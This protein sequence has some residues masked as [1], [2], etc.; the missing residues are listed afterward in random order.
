MSVPPVAFFVPYLR[1]ER[2][3][4]G[5]VLGGALSLLACTGQGTPP[6]RTP[7]ESATAQA[8]PDGPPPG[9]G[10]P[11]PEPPPRHWQPVQGPPAH[12]DPAV[13][14]VFPRTLGGLAFRGVQR[15][16]R[17]ELGYGLRYQNNADLWLDVYVYTLGHLRIPDGADASELQR[18]FTQVE[19]D[20]QA[21][22]RAGHYTQLV[23]GPRARVVPSGRIFQ[24]GSYTYRNR[25][26]S[27]ASRLYLS[28]HKGHYVKIRATWW[29]AMGAA[30][31]A[32]V[33]RAVRELAAL[34][35]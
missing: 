8:P 33:E 14:I 28:G 3:S 35:R 18:H 19:G 1:G 17:A 20:I 4:L 16:G 5:L 7:G 27:V 34:M 9:K 15:F 21:A 23:V 31:E 30:G 6:P 29:A 12:A 24:R 32:A 13:G 25:G 22:A 11:R 10:T 26:L 2:L